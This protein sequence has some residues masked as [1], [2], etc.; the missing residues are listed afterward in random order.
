MQELVRQQAQARPNLIDL[1]VNG[2]KMDLL[3][4]ASGCRE[5]YGKDE[6][7]D[8]HAYA[9]QKEW[10][11]RNPS[12]H[13]RVHLSGHM[14]VD[15][16]TRR[17]SLSQQGFVAMW[18][19]KT[20]RETVS[21]AIERAIEDAGY[22]P[23]LVDR[24]LRTHSIPDQVVHQ[25]R[26]SRFVVADLTSCLLADNDELGRGNVY[27]EAGFAA[28]KDLEVIFTCRADCYDEKKVASDIRHFHVVLWDDQ[29]LER[30]R[31]E[32]QERILARVRPGRDYGGVNSTDN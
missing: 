22:T 15:E 12:G 20:V 1:P 16:N 14:Y 13:I 21:P 17:E 9:E 2:G 31:Q 30:F 8:F 27:Y 4:A 19:N 10:I 11:W 6:L 32:L 18:F 7:E 28:G 25:L 24:D 3:Q 29:N 26:Q 23:F 5:S